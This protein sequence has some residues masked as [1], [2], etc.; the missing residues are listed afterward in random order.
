MRGNYL[1]SSESVSE[2]HPDKIADQ[3]SDA[4]LD[5]VLRQDPYGR[6]ACEVLLSNHLVYIVGE[7]TAQSSLDFEGIAR[8][9]IQDI[10]YDDPRKGLDGNHCSIQTAIQEQ[11]ADI[12]RGVQSRDENMGAGDQGI[13]FGYAVNETEEAMPLSIHLSHQLMRNLSKL[14]RQ[15]KIQSLFPD[16]KSQV[17]IEYENHSPKRIHSIVLSTQHSEDL[18]LSQLREFLMEELFKKTLPSHLLDSKTK[19]HINPTGRFVIGGPAGDSGLTGRK[20]IVDTYGGHGA[21]GGGAFSGKDPSKVDRSAA[22]ACRHIAKNIVISGIVDRCL[23]Q[24]SYAI[25]MAEPIHLYVNDYGTSKVPL[26]RLEAKIKEVWSLKPSN[27][28]E[29]LQ[30]LRPIYLKTATYGHFGR[31]GAERDTFTW[32]KTEHAEAFKSMLN[33]RV[34]KTKEINKKIKKIK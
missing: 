25:G 8:K 4:I 11:S 5:E 19:Y 10:G 33:G 3:I 21:H 26:E 2:G 7:I 9:L 6:V 16:A 28:I 34:S 20:I 29:N 15:N 17:T 27:T 32:E 12:G 31:G 13:I 18:S 24:V 1:F 14:R 30:L 23:L 22:Y